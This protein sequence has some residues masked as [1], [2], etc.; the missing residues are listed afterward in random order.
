MKL[1]KCALVSLIT[2]LPLL[3]QQPA[4]SAQAN[5][6]PQVV[7]S[8][9]GLVF[10]SKPEDVA[11]N[12]VS[13]PGVNTS[14]L[15]MLGADFQQEMAEYLGRPLTLDGLNQITHRVVQY[16][17]QHNHP[18]VDVVAPPQNV[19]S[20]VIQILVTEFRVGQVRVEG[21]QWFSDRVVAAAVTLQHGDTVDSQQL[22]NQ[23][24]AANTNPFRRVNLV[25]QPDAQQGYTDL[26][27]QTQDRLPLRV[28]TGFDN[29]GTPVTGRSRWELGATWGNALWRDQQLSYQL[30]TS[31]N[32]FTGGMPSE[33]GR[34]GGASFVGQSLT[35][36]MPIRSRDSISLTGNYD[37]SIPNIGQD[38]GLVGKSWGISSRYNL[39]LRR[40]SSLIH[41]ASIGYDFRSTN[42]NLAFG[43]AQVMRNT[44]EID[45]FVAGYSAN[46]TDHL[47]S[48]SLV[49]N[50]FFSP[51]NITPN[52]TN[53]A[54]Q[55]A[56]GQSGRYFDAAHY[57][58]WRSDLNRL[59]KL[60]AHAVWSV[61]AMGQTSTANLFY[62][63]Q[64]AGGGQEIMRGYDPNALLGDR[65]FLLSNELRSPSFLSNSERSLGTIQFLTFWDFAHL[66]SV[67]DVEG[68]VNHL[69]G[70][71]IGIG[72]RYNLRSNLTAKADYG[73]QLQHLPNSD[74]RDQLVSFALVMSY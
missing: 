29:G 9:K 8:L 14:A 56:A 60:P 33:D 19:D 22:L 38:F 67:H 51:G 45:Q 69:N 4:P 70:S 16:Y 65:G 7:P 18:L 30:S 58:Y 41:T 35:W 23:L 31:D 61:R 25:Y 50:L 40:T 2:A 49:T 44:V 71:S 32:F 43:G 54:M 73:W 63:E 34:P 24:D 13:A 6:N 46:L 52:N 26:V 36:T 21:N 62:T 20:G 42:N 39:A 53:A 72:T 12:G 28:F 59:T 1:T 68:A 47:G 57:T 15:D 10:L 3:A 17:R 74:N 37:R 66:S 55:P 11:K 27:L 48:T 64:L 5:G